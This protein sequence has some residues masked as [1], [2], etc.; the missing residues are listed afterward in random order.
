MNI[1]VVEKS[2]FCPRTLSFENLFPF[3][4]VQLLYKFYSHRRKCEKQVFHIH[5]IVFFVLELVPA[6]LTYNFSLQA[7]S[8]PEYS[9]TIYIEVQDVYCT[10]CWYFKVLVILQT[11]M[12]VWN[13]PRASNQ[14]IYF[15]KNW[16]PLHHKNKIWEQNSDIIDTHWIS[17]N[18]SLISYQW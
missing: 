16:T 13:P 18:K 2:A 14:K 12:N 11:C 17:L 15:W 10:L 5:F 7:T 8:V 4:P 9:K 1:F 3:C 6:F